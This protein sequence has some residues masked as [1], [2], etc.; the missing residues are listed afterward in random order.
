MISKFSWVGESRVRLS[1]EIR[2]EGISGGEGSGA[3]VMGGGAG[4]PPNKNFKE[5][6]PKGKLFLS[7]F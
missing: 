7:F 3:R 5:R 2:M 1:L 6:F 4:V